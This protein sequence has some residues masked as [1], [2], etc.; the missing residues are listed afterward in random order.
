MTTAERMD[1]LGLALIVREDARLDPSLV[2][3]STV[4]PRAIDWLWPG[5]I[6]YGKLTMLDGD[7]GLGKS[8]VCLDLAA[9]VSV[10]GTTPTGE[11]LPAGHVLIITSED[12]PDDTIRPRLDA[13]GGDASM[14][15]VLPAIELPSELDRLERIVRT[16]D[17]RLIIFDPLV[18]VLDAGVRTNQNMAVRK[19]L[20]PVVRLAADVGCAMVALRHLTKPQG[21]AKPS[22]AVYR[23]QDSIAF[24]GVV[25]SLLAVGQDPEDPD[26]FV[27]AS[28]K[29]NIGRKPPSLAYRLEADGPYAPARV[30]WEGETHLTAEELIGRHQESAG[31]SSKVAALA[32]SITA[33]VQANGGSMLASDGYRALEA[34]GIETEGD[35]AKMLIGR[36]RRKANIETAKS[37]FDGPWMWRLR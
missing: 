35:A 37:S 27:L 25:R 36:A 10:G 29:L 8:T 24:S 17:C 15:H 32:A 16:L 12:D 34:E 4:E 18:S 22:S 11:P 13:A 19:A 33:I 28:I 30:A 1:D 31:E 21:S 14:V 7:P 5:R 26:R 3:L 9:R 6:P 2:T 23:G 20:E